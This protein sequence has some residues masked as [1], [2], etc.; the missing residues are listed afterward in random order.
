MLQHIWSNY[1]AS[2]SCS[3]LLSPLVGSLKPAMRQ[4][5][6][7]CYYSVSYK[8]QNSL[9]KMVNYSSFGENIECSKHVT[10]I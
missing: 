3:H 5:Q 2:W 4:Q 7:L 10:F 9:N 1:T 8:T 6:Q